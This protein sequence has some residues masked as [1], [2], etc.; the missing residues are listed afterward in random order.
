MR[1]LSHA[2]PLLMIAAALTAVF[3]SG[4][5]HELSWHTLAAHEAALREQVSEHPARVAG[6]YF[7]TYV[8]AVAIALPIAEFMTIAGGVLFGTMPGGGLAALG[9]ATG[10]V[11]FFLAMRTSLGALVPRRPGGF[12][13]LDRFREGL[14]REEFSYL[15]A[16]RLLPVVPFWVTNLAPALLGMRLAP[17]AAATY[18]GVIPG[19]F[20]FASIG[21]GLRGVIASG[22]RPDISVLFSPPVLLPLL[23]LAALAL[24]PVA[25]RRWRAAGA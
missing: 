7:A 9:S 12:R 13:F 1:R 11:M 3:A 8:V 14:A 6:A 18:L 22:V 5:R 20:V 19:A 10:A 24:L 15:L 21:A 25:W 4:L 23:A 16:M 17:Y 2:W